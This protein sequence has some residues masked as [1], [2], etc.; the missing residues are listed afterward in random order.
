MSDRKKYQEYGHEYKRL[1]NLVGKGRKR[2]LLLG[3]MFLAMINFLLVLPA[4]MF[5]DLSIVITKVIVVMTSISLLL[6][7][8]VS[9]R[10]RYWR[11]VW[12]WGVVVLIPTMS[13]LFVVGFT[14]IFRG[15]QLSILFLVLTS[16]LFSMVVVFH[17]SKQEAA[18]W[19]L[20]R[21]KG[22]LKRCLDEENWVFDNDPDK[23]S[24][25]WFDLAKAEKT[26]GQH[27]NALKWLRRL[28]KLHFLMPGI[29]ISFR[30]TF[31]NEDITF[32][33][34]LVTIG[35]VFASIIRFPVY[36]KIREWEKEKGKPILLREIW[37]KEQQQSS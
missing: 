14:L 11:D 27:K 24:A 34:L 10:L 4:L 5:D 32:G 28:E 19:E 7:L 6:N 29:A 30:R 37:E 33:V 31:G 1:L 20:M 12:L 35:L 13:E 17:S 26:I 23:I 15:G 2:Y 22:L 8:I 25:V 9:M 16:V 21:S 18:K 36:L 3:L